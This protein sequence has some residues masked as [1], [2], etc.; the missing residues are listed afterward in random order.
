MGLVETDPN[1]DSKIEKD[2]A[3]STAKTNFVDDGIIPT[4]S[5]PNLKSCVFMFYVLCLVFWGE[6]NRLP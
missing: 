1:E 5:I 6:G 4:T 2:E 3:A